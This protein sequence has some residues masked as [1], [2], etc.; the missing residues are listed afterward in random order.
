VEFLRPKTVFKAI[1]PASLSRKRPL[2]P[3]KGRDGKP[4]A[5]RGQV[6][7]LLSTRARPLCVGSVAESR[8]TVPS[9]P[10]EYLVSGFRGAAH[11]QGLAVETTFARRE[12]KG[13]PT[14]E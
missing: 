8:A 13:T 12:S 3:G 4:R 9:N 10:G 1:T 14:P 6:T 5:A 11:A 7:A 2:S